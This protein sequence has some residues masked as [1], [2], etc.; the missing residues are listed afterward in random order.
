[1]LIFIF[2]VNACVYYPTYLIGWVDRLNQEFKLNYLQKYIAYLTDNRI[3]LNYKW[4]PVS[5]VLGND[6]CLC[7]KP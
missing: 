3:S 7:K 6:N 4:N 2:L 1:M 5:A